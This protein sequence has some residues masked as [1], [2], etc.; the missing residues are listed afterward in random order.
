M[1]THVETPSVQAATPAQSPTAMPSMTKRL[2]LLPSRRTSLVLTTQLVIIVGFLVLWEVAANQG[3]VNPLFVS[4]PSEVWSALTDYLTS[5]QMRSSMGATLIAVIQSFVIGSVA[6]VLIGCVLGTNPFLD[7]VFGPFLVPLNAVPRIAL[8]PLFVAWFGL[9]G[10]SKVVM[11][12]S[13]VFF[14]LVENSRSA[15]KGVDRD[16][17]TMARVVGLNKRQLMTKVILPSA[18]P[19]IFA[20]LRLAI[21]YAILGVIASEMIAAK[22]GLGQDIVRY[23]SEFQINYVFAVLIVLA[24]LAT[25]AS[26]GSSRFERRLLRWQD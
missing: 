5:E 12:V 4:K 7:R 21:T 16:Q 23:S 20:G 1:T 17:M 2:R 22:N 10:T 26:V 25:V 15:V 24:A 11:G 18:V 13:I 6:G 19:T 3:W 8:A 9:T 14:L